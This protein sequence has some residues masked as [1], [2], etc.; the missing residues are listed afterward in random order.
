MLMLTSF[1]APHGHRGPRSAVAV[2]SAILMGIS[3]AAMGADTAPAPL[4]A[5]S[6]TVTGSPVVDFGGISRG[7]LTPVTGGMTPG[8]RRLVISAGCTLPRSMRLRIDG[9]AR[10]SDFSWNGTDSVL[11]LTARE[12]AVDTKAVLLQRLNAAGSPE[13]PPAREITLAPGDTLVAMRDGIPAEGRQ[14]S[15]VLDITPVLGDRDSHPTARADMMQSLTI[16][17]VP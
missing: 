6:C 7:R 17:L 16:G 4:T 5:P 11:R 13:G 12:G 9:A 1:F 14:L 8:A 15:M 3:T 2:L 10:G